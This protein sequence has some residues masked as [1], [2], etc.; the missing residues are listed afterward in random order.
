[1]A[2]GDMP[3]VQPASQV[4]DYMPSATRWRD[5]WQARYDAE[6][7]KRGTQVAT[8]LRSLSPQT[9]AYT[10]ATTPTGWQDPNTGFWYDNGGNLTS[11]S[12]PTYDQSAI[13]KNVGLD[14][15]GYAIARPGNNGIT[16]EQT[17]Y[18]TKMPGTDFNVF[19]PQSESGGS[20]GYLGTGSAPDNWETNYE[21]YVPDFTALDAEWEQMLPQMEKQ[22]LGQTAYDSMSGWGQVN[23][24]PGP[25]YAKPNFGRVTDD[26]GQ[27][28]MGAGE[29]GSLNM[30]WAA[31]PSAAQAKG[32]GMGVYAPRRQTP[33]Q[34][35][36]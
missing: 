1:M 35:G 27:Y 3:R 32:A 16:A 2:F 21:T 30:D 19:M 29:F 9:S 10:K 20:G 26:F 12:N 6:E 22:Q 24:I 13:P 15:D 33:R 17:A 34:W 14:K 18:G 8:G 36:L 7:A 4:V 11:T 31:D 28:D 23:A 25:D 5:D